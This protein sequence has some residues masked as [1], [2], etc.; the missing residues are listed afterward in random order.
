MTPRSRRSRKANAT[1][2][3]AACLVVLAVA[4]LR[5][6]LGKHNYGGF[7]RTAGCYHGPNRHVTL[8]VTDSA[9]DIQP[10]DLGRTAEG[11]LSIVLV[12]HWI[13]HWHALDPVVDDAPPGSL[14]H[15]KLGHARSDDPDLPA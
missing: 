1:C 13:D 7:Y 12:S 5:P 3:F 15:R 2:A 8:D 10:I 4:L 14:L 6:T 9:P 11:A